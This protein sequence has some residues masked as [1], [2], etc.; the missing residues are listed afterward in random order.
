M[1]VLPFASEMAQT[2]D[3]IE[4]L[5]VLWGP[6]SHRLI[7]ELERLAHLLFAAE[8]FI[9]A[10][11]SYWRLLQ[12]QHV[13]LGDQNLEVARI[14][15]RLGELYFVQQIY[16]PAAQL[17]QTAAVILEKC[18]AYGEPLYE[19]VLCQW[20]W[21]CRLQDCNQQASLIE[22]RLAALR[23]RRIVDSE[24]CCQP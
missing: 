20:L 9:E 2:F 15:S 10:E 7:P 22:A 24:F 13:C 1:Q 14:M 4:E 21:T 8:R 11:Q 16:G 6:S 3:R 17:Y 19:T 23:G 5:E 12:L 18:E